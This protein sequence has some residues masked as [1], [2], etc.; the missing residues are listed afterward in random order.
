MLDILN[1]KA[2]IFTLCVYNNLFFV[3]YKFFFAV[4][5]IYTQDKNKKR[6]NAEETRT[7]KNR[8]GKNINKNKDKNYSK[9]RHRL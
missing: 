6:D 4:F 7:A 3:Y 1:K 8:T 2:S 9:I 5:F